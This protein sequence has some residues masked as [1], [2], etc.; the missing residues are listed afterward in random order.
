[1][2]MTADQILAH[3]AKHGLPCALSP[4]GAGPAP[5][6][7]AEPSEAQVRWTKGEEKELSRLVVTDLRRRGCIV[8]VSRTDKPTG[9]DR[10]V[11]D[12]IVMRGGKVCCIE[13]KAGRNVLSKAQIDYHDAL[14]AAGVP[15]TTAWNFDDA[16]KFAFEKLDL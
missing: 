11:P 2:K 12:L 15:A 8:V 13:L 16:I 10:G 7:A 6:K 1:M 5:E 9:Q 4:A 3:A 14:I